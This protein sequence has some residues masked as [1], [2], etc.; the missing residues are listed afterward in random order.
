ML[1]KKSSK[2]LITC[3]MVIIFIV[4]TFFLAIVD[5]QTGSS[6]EIQQKLLEIS[7]EEK[8]VLEQLFTL[9][10]EIETLERQKEKIIADIEVLNEQIAELEKTVSEET[11]LYKEKQEALKAVLESYQRGGAVSYLKIILES[12]SLSALL[13]R[14][15]ILRDFT[16]NMGQLLKGLEHSREKLLNEG[17]VLS[18]KFE[19]IENKQKKMEASIADNLKK[20]DE[21]EKILSS[22]GEAREYYQNNL[23]HIHAMWDDL[24]II[25]SETKKEFS[26]IIENEDLPEEA[27]KI[28]FTLSGI[29]G[30]M[31]E[32]TFN[33]IIA[34]YSSFLEVLFHFNSDRVEMIIPEKNLTLFGQFEILDEH[35]IKFEIEGGNFYDLSLEADTIEELF[36]EWNMSLNFKPLIGNSKIKSIKVLDG[37]VELSIIPVL[38]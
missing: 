23:N 6:T 14:I 2:F 7:G 37:Y 10:Q 21:I 8:E 16:H 32:Q 13:R 25:L 35:I 3:V 28:T 33:D 12:D 4:I 30:S 36:S 17:I 29:K 22:M 34:E 38:F 1:R 24:K 11:K 15:N 20:K 5:G 26:R 9:I 27:L 19:E 18:E 31:E